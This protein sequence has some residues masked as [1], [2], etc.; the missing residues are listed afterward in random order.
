MGIRQRVVL[1]AVTGGLLVFGGILS[2]CAI[3]RGTLDVRAQQVANP[4][5]GPAVRFVRVTDRREFELRPPKPS[6]PS[7]KDGEIANRAVTSRAIAR[8]R[9]SYGKAMGDILLPEGRTVEQLTEESLS[10]AFRK[11]GY[12][13]LRDGDAG[14]ASAT[15]LEVDIHQF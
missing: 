15:P 4:A 3:T 7:L 10:V 12:R 1:L 6:I 14:F 13:V 8:K 9:N 5:R 11:G 2:G